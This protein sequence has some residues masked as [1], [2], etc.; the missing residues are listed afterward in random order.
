MGSRLGKKVGGGGGGEEWSESR[1]ESEGES[2]ERNR[3]CKKKFGGLLL[4]QLFTFFQAP[5]KQKEWE[6][7]IES[8]MFAH[9]GQFCHLL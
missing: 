7:S 2:G 9:S 8:P 6:N 4:Y 5:P 3:Y 1:G